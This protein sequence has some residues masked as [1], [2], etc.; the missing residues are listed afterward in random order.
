MTGWPKSSARRVARI[1]P[2]TSPVPPA[3][4]SG[5]ET[6]TPVLSQYRAL[7][8]WLQMRVRKV[9][10]S[11][12]VALSRPALS[13]NSFWLDVGCLDDRP[14]FLDLGLLQ[15]GKCIRRLLLAWR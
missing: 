11:L 15:H 9:P 12:Q 10:L 2:Y 6:A 3:P 5:A 7:L 1:R 14:P 4:W 13:L 8:K